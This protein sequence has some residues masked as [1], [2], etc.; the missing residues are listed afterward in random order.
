MQT[1]PNDS[2]DFATGIS[3]GRK[4]TF[5]RSSDFLGLEPVVL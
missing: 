4:S 3:P 5:K 2:D 1:S